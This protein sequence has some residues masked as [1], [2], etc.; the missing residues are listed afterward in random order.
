M[1]SSVK[2]L[3]EAAILSSAFIII[4]MIALSTGIGYGLY[5]DFGVPIIFALIYFRCDF[6]YTFMC[7]IS[8]VILILFVMGNFAA[9]LLV[10]QSFLIGLICGY[11]ISKS[12]QLFDDLF[13]G[14]IMGVVFMVLID[15]Y[16]RNIIGYSFMQ[17][18]QGYIDYMKSK[19][20]ILIEVAPWI[21]DINFE[22]LYYLLIAIFPFGM[23]FS[24]YIISV[25]C[26]KRLRILSENGKRKYFMVR[27]IRS[28]GSF[29][30]IRKKYFYTAILYIILVNILEMS[31]I[32]FSNVYLKTIIT[33]VQYLSYYFV[34]RDTH[35]LIGNFI[36]IKFKKKSLNLIYLLVTLILLCNVFRITVL[37]YVI[38]SLYMDKKYNLREKQDYIVKSHIDKLMEVY[39]IH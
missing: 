23:V 13:I 21:T 2:K 8:S 22:V 3:T 15:I 19:P 5:L 36:N 1:N 27:A 29:M 10:S 25:I 12:S 9:A 11:L 18:F 24:I 34:F 17:E 38:I 20:P 35:I 32:R 16:A 6:K 31:N 4:T 37:T 39:E 30:N 26:G 33:C 28:C 7:G 14:S